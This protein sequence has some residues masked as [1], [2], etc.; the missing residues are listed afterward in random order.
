MRPG[1]LP[2]P[3]LAPYQRGIASLMVMIFLLVVVSFAAVTLLKIASSDM[4]DS[5]VQNESVPA[6]FLAETAVERASYL[7][8]NG[9]ACGAGLVQGPF[10]YGDGSFQILAPSPSPSP[11]IVNGLCRFWARGK[12]GNTTRTIQT[13]LLGGIRFIATTSKQTILNAFPTLTWSHT[14]AAASGP[15]RIL[16]VGVSIR[17][18]GSQTVSSITYNGAFLKLV[19]AGINPKPQGGIR[20]EIWY[21]LNPPTG[22]YPVTVTLTA[23]A[24]MVGGAVSFSGVDQTTPFELPIPVFP[25]GNNAPSASITVPTVSNDDWVV[26]VLAIR[27]P[28]PNGATATMVAAPGRAPLWNWLASGGS[29]ASQVLGA[30]SVRGPITPPGNVTM[31]WTFS[32]STSWVLGAVGLRPAP[33]SVVNWQEM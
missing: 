21:L 24:K 7:Y 1:Y 17:Q 12:A 2:N 28:N 25:T 31:N 15:D 26:D 30:G 10:A 8:A 22:T 5:T 14:I 4:H 32:R 27:Q 6:L 18:T 29:R 16:V 23:A 3:V 19:G 13:D 33:V 20:V 9:T 11:L